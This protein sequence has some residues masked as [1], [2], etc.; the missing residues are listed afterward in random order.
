M[1]KRDRIDAD[2]H[3]LS[4]DFYAL[5][6]CRTNSG[7]L[8]FRGLDR[9][10]FGPRVL[11]HGSL[12]V[13]ERASPHI[14]LSVPLAPAHPAAPTLGSVWRAGACGG[15]GAMACARSFCAMWA[16]R[17]LPRLMCAVTPRS[18]GFCAWSSARLDIV[19]R[20]NVQCADY[21]GANAS[22]DAA[23]KFICSGMIAAPGR[24]P[25]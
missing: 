8:V 12:A 1:R 17:C 2:K 7:Q 21:I 19:P 24:G 3:A 11:Q 4:F 16:R 22:R 14:I 13:R 9:L 15:R 10:I 23:S 20:G 18:S 25:F 6:L 5:L